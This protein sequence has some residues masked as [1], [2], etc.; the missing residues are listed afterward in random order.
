MS[1][2]TWYDIQMAGLMYRV[3]ENVVSE[4]V[5]WSFESKFELYSDFKD[6]FQFELKL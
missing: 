2:Q 3:S 1:E 5:I 4:V 6:E